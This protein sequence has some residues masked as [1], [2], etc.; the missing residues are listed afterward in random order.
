MCVLW[1]KCPYEK[2]LETYLMILV[3]IYIYMYV[4]V[5]VCV[6]VWVCVCVCVCMCVCSPIPPYELD[7]TQGQLLNGVLQVWIQNFSSCLAKVKAI[8][9]SDY[10]SII[11]GRITDSYLSQRHKC[12]VECKQSLSRLEH[13]SLYPLSTT[14]THTHTHTHTHIYIYIYIYK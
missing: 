12:S 5:C 2:S 4:C 9:L 7:V 6:C 8:N 13:D 11:G 3:Y 1:I 10:L 14:I